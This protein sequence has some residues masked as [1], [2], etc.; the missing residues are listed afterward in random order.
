[1]KEIKEALACWRD[2]NTELDSQKG[3]RVLIEL[4]EKV[5]A[6]EGR[7]PE[8]LE[9]IEVDIGVGMMQ[10][11]YE[12]GFNDAIDQCTIAITGALLS[13]PEINEVVA[14]NCNACFDENGKDV[15]DRVIDAIHKA[16]MGPTSF[17]NGNIS[18]EDF[19]SFIDDCEQNYDGTMDVF[20]YIQAQMEKPFWMPLPPKPEDVEV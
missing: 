10:S 19:K 2:G 20:A 13:V 16:Q 18:L 5:L 12:H 1:M 11:S 6:V 17:H 4:A 8:K 15:T 9:P 3:L 7:V 14:C